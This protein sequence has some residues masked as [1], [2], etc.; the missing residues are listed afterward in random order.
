M[1]FIKSSYFVSSF[2]SSSLIIFL[3]FACIGLRILLGASC[4]ILSCSVCSCPGFSFLTGASPLL[5]KSAAFACSGE[6]GGF[7][8]SEPPTDT[9]ITPPSPVPPI[10]TSASPGNKSCP[11]NPRPFSPFLPTGTLTALFAISL[12]SSCILSPVSTIFFSLASY[13]GVPSLN[14]FNSWNNLFCSTC[15][16]LRSCTN[17]ATSFSWDATSSIPSCFLRSCSTRIAW[18]SLGEIS[19]E[20]N[21]TSKTSPGNDSI[22]PF[23]R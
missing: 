18:D 15:D 20:P 23:L 19:L 8:S 2:E 12:S 9:L 7:L 6:T 21:L 13:S 1:F 22:E 16:S 17:E 4:T 11:F 14:N 3:Y 10:G 5:I